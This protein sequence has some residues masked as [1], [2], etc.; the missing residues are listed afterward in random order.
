MN[1]GRFEDDFGPQSDDEVDDSKPGECSFPFMI[2]I[3]LDCKSILVFVCVL[4][5]F[6]VS[7]FACLCLCVP[8]LPWSG[9]PWPAL[10]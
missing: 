2:V 8:A 9:L 1:K 10:A 6:P 4:T 5:F 3:A 7:V